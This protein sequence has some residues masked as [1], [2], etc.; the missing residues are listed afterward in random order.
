MNNRRKLVIALGAGALTVPFDSVAQLQ[1]KVWR[2]G[3]L[4]PYPSDSDQQLPAFKQQLRDSGH[5]EGKTFTIDYLSAEGDYDRLPALASD[6]VKRN[7]D[8]ILAAGGT[9]AAI[10]AKN[11]TR[12]IPVVFVGVADPVGQGIVASLARPG[13]N[14][15]GISS[16]QLETA[17]RSLALL[18]ETIPSANRV[19]IL[20]NPTNLSLAP[21]VKQVLAAGKT[22]RLDLTVINVK[23]P[24]ELE[25]AFAEIARIRPAGVVILVDAMFQNEAARITA[26]AAK[27]S[28]PTM[29]GHNVIPEAG[30]LMSYG[31]NRLDLVRLA[32]ILVEKILKGAKPGDL[33]IQQPTKFDLVINMKTAKMLG[34]KIPN[35]V[36]L[37]ATR[38]IK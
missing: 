13:G 1:R 7:V 2:I 3:F 8:V 22:L 28:L 26:L 21:V 24:G 32:A 37:Q 15:T 35:A 23:A 5:V 17:D 9:P 18:K 29:G 31:S 33:P 6:L 16:Q 36:M 14:V 4:S 20:S 34:I 19:V 30:G 12:T 10:P 25:E 38:V 11:A 27:F